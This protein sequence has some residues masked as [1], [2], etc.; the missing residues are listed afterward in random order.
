VWPGQPSAILAEPA[1]LSA[2]APGGT[3]AF[4]PGG[5]KCRVV[6]ATKKTMASSMTLGNVR[7]QPNLDI[8]Q[9]L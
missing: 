6:M 5:I 3:E 1:E 4:A 2:G 8:D 9:N 7:E